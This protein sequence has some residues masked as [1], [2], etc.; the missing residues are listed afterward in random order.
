MSK[1]I[2][3]QLLKYACYGLEGGIPPNLLVALILERKF[4]TPH[5]SRNQAHETPQSREAAI[6][7]N[8]GSFG[9]YKFYRKRRN[10]AHKDLGGHHQSLSGTPD[11]G[12]TSPTKTINMG[13]CLEPD[14][15]DVTQCLASSSGEQ[16]VR[17]PPQVLGREKPC[18]LPSTQISSKMIKF[19]G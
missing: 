4:L 9:S 17:V 18:V 12:L 8:L 10:G 6:L 13:L 19:P 1:D 5:T 14:F 15:Y 7:C 11:R 16:A 2:F 3:F